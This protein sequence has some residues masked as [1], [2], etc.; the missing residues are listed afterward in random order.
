[1]FGA[2]V[3]VFEK[4]DRKL[5]QSNKIGVF[6]GYSATTAVVLY[7]DCKSKEI[8]RCHHARIDDFLQHPDT[9]THFRETPAAIMIRDLSATTDSIPPCT[10]ILTH[11]QSP[12]AQEDLYTY[13][14]TLP[15]KGPL[16]LVL[17]DDDD[18]G[19]PII[20]SMHPTS[21]F[22]TGCKKVLTKNTWIISIHY[23]E[24]T[25]VERFMQYV[26]HLRETNTLLVSVTLSKRPVTVPTLR[27]Q[28]FR[29][30]F[31][32]MRPITNKANSPTAKFAIHSP[33][34]PTAPS[35]FKE[36][37]SSPY[38][39]FWIKSMFERY[40][41]FHKCGTWSA[42]IPRKNL[43]P[44]ATVLDAVST[45]KIKKTDHPTMW[46]LNYRP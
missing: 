6:L 1:M 8:K 42:P 26:D 36:F 32:Q 34:K 31:D 5:V 12:F 9:T 25:T 39:E 38:K 15:S 30:R 35:S 20:V 22:L 4:D 13:D 45:F 27:Y 37:L 14:V 44:D 41:K 11:V 46:D 2:P 23:E 29:Y 17:D 18:F 40:T 28:E 21:P 19:L 3:Y 24:P 33:V 43:P 7:Q 10:D 16:G